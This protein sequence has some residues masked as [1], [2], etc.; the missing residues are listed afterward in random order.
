MNWWLF[1]FILL[2]FVGS[3]IS[4]FIGWFA[5]RK[6]QK[7]YDKQITFKKLKENKDE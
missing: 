6:Y 1:L 7:I 2:V 4:F 5:G 3:I